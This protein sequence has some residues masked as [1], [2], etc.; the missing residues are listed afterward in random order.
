MSIYE[1]QE[2]NE[3]IDSSN[4]LRPLFTF[5]PDAEFVEY[6][7]QNH[8]PI[9]ITIDGTIYYDGQRYA[10]CI[11]SANFPTFGA[12]YFEATNKYVMVVHTDFTLF[13]ETNGVMRIDYGVRAPAPGPCALQ[14]LTLE[15]FDDEGPYMY[16]PSK[17]G[18]EQPDDKRVVGNTWSLIM[19]GLFALIFLVITTAIIYNRYVL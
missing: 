7:Q 3:T 1:I 13:P 14:T 18:P 4:T 10:T 17:V 11:S 6:L 19:I 2:W 8:G 15:G 12:N 9:V 16:D 5:V